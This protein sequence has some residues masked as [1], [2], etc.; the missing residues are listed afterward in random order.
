MKLEIVNGSF[1]YEP[2]VQILKRLNLSIEEGVF[3]CILGPNGI[4]KTT[5][6]KCLTGILKWQEGF[7]RFNHQKTSGISNLQEV[8]YVPQ[9]HKV[10][11]P[12][13]A[14]DMVCMGRTKQMKFFAMPSKLDQRIAMESL[15]EMNIAHLAHRK[16]NQMSGGQL[17][18]VYIAR[19]LAA[20]PRVLILDEPESHLDFKNQA[21]IIQKLRQ[22]V[23][24]QKIACIMNTHNPE[25]AMKIA[26]Q[27]LLLG[28]GGD[29]VFGKTEEVLTEANIKKFFE[30]E[31]HIVDLHPLGIAK[32]AFVLKD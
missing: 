16:S 26:D 30:V 8:S 31:A 18:M 28:E 5:F 23:K 6:L 12:Y 9:A 32:K 13:T 2:Q 21:I 14:L 20:K 29:Y 19:A 17:Q 25:H 11:F 22:L 1:A 10:S 24:E 15:E 3:L 4:G 27:I 7:T